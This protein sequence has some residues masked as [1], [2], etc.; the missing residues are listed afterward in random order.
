[1]LAFMSPVRSG[2]GRGQTCPVAYQ[3]PIKGNLEAR[4]RTGYFWS[5][6]LHYV[7]NTSGHVGVRAGQARRAIS[8]SS[9][10]FSKSRKIEATAITSPLR[11]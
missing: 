4:L 1:M 2:I 3:Q 5:Q 7:W 6:K 11:R 10:R 8:T 9:L